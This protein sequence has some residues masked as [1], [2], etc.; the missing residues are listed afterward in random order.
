MEDL[1]LE[2]AREELMNTPA[3]AITGIQ[4]IDTPDPIFERIFTT[5]NTLFG[6]EPTWAACKVFAGKMTFITKLI[7]LEVDDL[8][9]ENIA[10]L[11]KIV[12]DSDINPDKVKS[13]SPLALNLYNWMVLMYRFGRMCLEIKKNKEA[14]GIKE[15]NEKDE[16]RSCET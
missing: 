14:L 3:E 15:D 11:R 2:Q 7:E 13:I 5:V 12:N 10:N 6:Y 4:S 9:P 8:T 1:Q 16:D